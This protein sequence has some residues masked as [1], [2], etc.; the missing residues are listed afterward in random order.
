LL[1]LVAGILAI[2]RRR[3]V[4]VPKTHSSARRAE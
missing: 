3:I 1:I 2:S 4:A